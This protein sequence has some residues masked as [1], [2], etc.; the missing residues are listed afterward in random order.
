[1]SKERK[2]LVLDGN[3]SQCLPIIRSLY[4]EGHLI[5]LVCPGIFSS[6]YFS[7]YV[8]KKLIW[9][10]ITANKEEFYKIFL[11]HIESEH[12]DWV[13]GLSDVS[14]DMLSYH[15]KKIEKF[16]K[17]VVPDYKIYSMA[18]DKYLTMQLCMKK[19]IPCPITISGDET[20][21][22]ELESML[23]FPV[24]VKP[25]KGVGAVGFAIF[26]DRES[27]INKLPSLRTEYGNLLI[28][29]YIPN[30]KQYTA[31][32]FCDNNS[33]MK[34]CIISEKI[35]F[36][37]VTG[38]TSS[39]NITIQSS[40]MALIAERL[41]KELKWVGAANIDFILDPRDNISK[42]IEI[43]PRIGAT[44]KIAFVS[45]IDFSKMLLRLAN[46][47]DIEQIECYKSGLIMRN[48]ILDTIWFIFS[49]AQDRKKTIP[50]FFK[51]YDKR[52]Y[53][54]AF[55][56]D[57]PLPILGFFIGYIIKYA[58]IK[59]LRNKLGV[60]IRERIQSIQEKGEYIIR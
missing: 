46:G 16:V 32:V 33:N 50:A 31:E 6:G 14:T 27:L 5:T 35:R 51:F 26:Y 37:P 15:K 47:R 3:S 1:M 30:R 18:A 10:R 19:K 41:L 59:R 2:I 23:S 58:N 38:G 57:D 44:I 49:S 43:N 24:V 39:C 36:F 17:T 45:G 22:E 48:L 25:K 12:Y 60:N 42:V 11:S 9:P 21:N 40:E 13:L 29:E 55:S 53:Y 8:H 34:A 20:D 54:Q 7:R 56:K 4:K 28:Q 52:I